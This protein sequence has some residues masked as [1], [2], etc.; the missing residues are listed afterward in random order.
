M[1]EYG[2]EVAR[3]GANSVDQT[4]VKLQDLSL[5]LRQSRLAHLTGQQER[6]QWEKAPRST[7]LDPK[8]SPSRVCPGQVY[9]LPRH[10]RTCPE[11]VEGQERAQS[12]T[13]LHDTQALT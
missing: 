7:R 13:H 3:K 4:L 10:T 12:L 1:H 8:G 11:G 9:I 2:V 6:E 5:G